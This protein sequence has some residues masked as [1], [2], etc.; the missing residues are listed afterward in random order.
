MIIPSAVLFH[1]I[2]TIVL[3]NFVFHD[4]LYGCDFSIWP[5][6]FAEGKL[7]HDLKDVEIIVPFHGLFLLLVSG[8]FA[9]IIYMLTS[10][11]LNLYGDPYNRII[12]IIEDKP[13]E[14]EEL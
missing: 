14:V 9:K 3:E 2:P 4:N 6:Y 5:E 11:K 1:I 12:T 13:E 10:K 8:T 7:A